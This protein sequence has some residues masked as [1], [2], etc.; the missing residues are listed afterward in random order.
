MNPDLIPP[1]LIAVAALILAY[2]MGSVSAAIL[3]CRAM[4]LPDP[5]TDG[6]R[7]P[8]T[9]NVLR[10]GGKPAAMLTL[11][12]D[13]LKGVIP[14]VLARKLDIDDLMLSAVGFA[15]FLGHLYPVFF[16]FEGGKGV[17]TALGVMLALHWVLGLAVIAIWL[18]GFALT[19]ISSV[20][21]IAGFLAAPFLAGYL[22]P[23][24]MLG[25][26]VTSLFLLARH[27]GNIKA[28]LNGTESKFGKK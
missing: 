27:R 13:M 9:T 5:R 25:I 22:M 18:A 6:S 8:G 23:E 15:A 11:A 4:G 17:A 24:G 10:I 16:R 12:G 2:L 21:A 14:V 20:G 26:L 19:R 3:V 1:D 7:N 28:L